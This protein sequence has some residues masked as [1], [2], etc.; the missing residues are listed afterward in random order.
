MK[1]A[2]PSSSQRINPGEDVKTRDIPKRILIVEDNAIIAMELKTDLK[3]IGYVVAGICDTGEEAITIV[4]AKP[5][6]IVIMDIVLAGVLDGVETAEIILR[7]YAIP[8]VYLTA[9]SDTM[10]F[11]R[12]KKTNP[13]GYLIKPFEIGELN[14]I[15]EIAVHKSMAE[16]QLHESETLFRTLVE[17]SHDGIFI[18]RENRM[19]YVNKAFAELFGHDHENLID[20]ALNRFFAA[21]DIHLIETVIHQKLRGI[22]APKDIE[23]KACHASGNVLYVVINLSVTNYQGLISVMGVVKD[24][25]FKKQKEIE[26]IK[27]KKQFEYE[28]YLK[29][30]FVGLISHEIRTPVNIIHGYVSILT[31]EFNG[32]ASDIQQKALEKVS[33]SAGKLVDASKK[34]IEYS[35]LTTNTYQMTKTE[36]LLD[37]DII[38]PLLLDFTLP[39]RQKN[40]YISFN[41]NLPGAAVFS[42]MAMTKK[43]MAH[44]LDNAVKYT[45][46]GSVK[47]H[48]LKDTDNR[49]V[50]EIQDTGPGI[51]NTYIENLFLND[52]EKPKPMP[53]SYNGNGLGLTMVKRYAELNNIEVHLESIKDTGTIAKVIFN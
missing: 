46:K 22:A 48:L 8:V 30:E 37:E 12:A 5:V 35:Q 27:S 26:L 11:E 25:T 36:V 1:L 51:D 3:K 29:A 38:E 4:R 10:T 2:L 31:D 45:R 52:Y 15:L 40:L 24:I 47:V 34:I 23:V 33:E 39:A 17:S 20:S 53:R 49:V 44:L 19:V 32:R 21:E 6:D 7:D 9:H 42:D 50:V 18:M 13:H 43:L 41:N 28:D 16:R 14:S